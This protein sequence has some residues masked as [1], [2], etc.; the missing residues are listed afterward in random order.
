[1][2]R[3]RG[4]PQP[5]GEMNVEDDAR[6]TCGRREGKQARVR[7][8]VRKAQDG[9]PE[10]KRLMGSAA[11][12]RTAAACVFALLL[13]IRAGKKRGKLRALMYGAA[14][15]VVLLSCRPA[16]QESFLLRALLKLLG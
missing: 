7:P 3:P 13:C 4:P 2:V 16:L 1:M 6:S 5:A 12:F 11:W 10:R 15:V 14:L 9:A 8:C